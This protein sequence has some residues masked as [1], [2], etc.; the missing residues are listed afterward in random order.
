MDILRSVG[1]SWVTTPLVTGST[2]LDASVAD[3]CLTDVCS[4]V[5]VTAV[6]ETF[7]SGPD[8]SSVVVTSKQ[9]DALTPST[10]NKSSLVLG[11][12]TFTLAPG[13]IIPYDTWLAF[14]STLSNLRVRL[15]FS[16]AAI[17]FSEEFDDNSKLL[18]L[19]RKLAGLGVLPRL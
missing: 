17:A 15:P 7:C 1:F 16:L 19:L 2:G 5:G 4:V 3:I 13:Y 6:V 14:L 11:V 9:L 8:W 10:A 18:R 12:R